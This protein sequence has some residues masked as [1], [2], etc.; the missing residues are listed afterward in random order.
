MR[1]FCYLK[2]GIDDSQAKQGA[3]ISV[4]PWFVIIHSTRFSDYQYQKYQDQ[5]L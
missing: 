5:V 1:L 3:T 2:Y 4:A